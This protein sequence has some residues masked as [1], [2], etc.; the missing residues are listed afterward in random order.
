[1]LWAQSGI[2]DLS[3]T[4]R[5]IFLPLKITSG[6][7]YMSSISRWYIVACIV[8][9]HDVARW[10]GHSYM[11]IARPRQMGRQPQPLANWSIDGRKNNSRK[12]WTR[13]RTADRWQL[14]KQ[15]ACY[16]WDNH[17]SSTLLWGYLQVSNSFMVQ[18]V[19]QRR[20]WQHRRYHVVTPSGRQIRA[21]NCI[22]TRPWPVR[23]VVGWSCQSSHSRCWLLPIRPEI[24]SS[25]APPEHN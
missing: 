10:H 23:S 6:S 17:A 3:D 12:S 20:K 24:E 15:S 22:R 14:C 9:L 13:L 4:R 18:T 25:V 2:V 19:L 7:S 11:L 1:M 16:A 8:P 21:P 5:S